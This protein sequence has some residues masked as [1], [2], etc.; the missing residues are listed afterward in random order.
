MAY[1]GGKR[2]AYDDRALAFALARQTKPTSQIAREFGLSE[3]YVRKIRRGACR[4]RVQRMIRAICEKA[5]DELSDRACQEVRTL[6]EAQIRTALKGPRGLA[7]RCREYLLD[8]FLLPMGAP[9]PLF[10]SLTRVAKASRTPRTASG[11]RRKFYDEELLVRDVAEGRLSL[12]KIAEKHHVAPML[13]CQIRQGRKRPDLTA[14]IDELRHLILFE[15]TCVVVP[16][17]KALVAKEARVGNTQNNPTA[18]VC[19]EYML[20]RFLLSQSESHAP[21]VAERWARRK[22]GRRWMRP[23]I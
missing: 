8:R 6:L 19:R 18:R 11:R 15:S 13:V 7:R 17:L 5:D 2:K 20:D 14:R 10:E 3:E 9:D 4:P 1:R 16:R 22:N 12:R 21:R 23:R